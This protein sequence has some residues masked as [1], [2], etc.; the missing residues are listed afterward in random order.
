MC[1]RKKELNDK[2]FLAISV[3]DTGIGISQSKI[4][5][6]F[7]PFVQADESTSRSYGGTGLGLS[8]CKSLIEIIGGNIQVESEL[9]SWSKFSFTI[10]LVERDSI[11]EI[12]QPKEELTTP[13]NTQKH[14]YNIL[15]AEDSPA[16]RELVK[17]FLKDQPFSVTTVETGIDA[18]NIFTK[19]RFDCIL[20]DI[21]MPGM[22]GLETTSKIRSV[23]EQNKYRPIPIIMLTAHAL[24]DYE[25]KAKEVGCNAFLTKPLHKDDLLR[26]LYD[27]LLSTQN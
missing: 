11:Q 15:L 21:E 7:D 24:S 18:L 14:T 22:D 26:Q 17:L 19:N 20:M 8:I 23:E 6:I 16:N 1:A 4:N 25:Q 9:G 5:C 2:Q 13:T 27:S 10:P 3:L 12:K